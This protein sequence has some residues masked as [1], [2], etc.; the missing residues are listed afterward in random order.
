[1]KNERK[2]ER[3]FKWIQ[4]K[5][6]PQFIK[7]YVFEETV[8][9]LVV[10]KKKSVRRFRGNFFEPIGILGR[11]FSATLIEKSKKYFKK[12]SNVTQIFGRTSKLSS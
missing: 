11:K 1:M 7:I 12:L 10:F 6:Q 8:T 2:L 5:F 3:S 9:N 4:W